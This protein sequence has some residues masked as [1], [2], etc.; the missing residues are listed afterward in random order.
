[1]SNDTIINAIYDVFSPL[2]GRDNINIREQIEP[3][4]IVISRPAPLCYFLELYIST[5]ENNN[6]LVYKLDNCHEKTMGA[7]L[8]S[9]VEILAK[10]IGSSQ[11]K[12]IDASKLEIAGSSVSLK[13]LYNLTAGQS[14]Y[15][16]LGYICKDEDYDTALKE[17]KTK[18]TTTT[19]REFSEE[20]E[21]EIY[22]PIDGLLEDIK[23]E[24]PEFELDNNKTIQDYFTIVKNILQQYNIG[25]NR[26][27]NKNIRLLIDIVNFADDANIITTHIVKDCILIKDMKTSGGKTASSR[28]R[29]KHNT[30]IKKTK[31]IQPLLRKRSSL[32]KLKRSKTRHRNKNKK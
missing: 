5:T 23:E 9:S 22:H 32:N 11:I 30:I 21:R 18:I 25:N 26:V 7:K 28:I 31:K 15:N 19:M 6:I 12:L 3:I 29:K 1:M 14:W 20:I 27:K 2:V 17:N 13:T 8:L 4:Y 16:K 24:F 10:R